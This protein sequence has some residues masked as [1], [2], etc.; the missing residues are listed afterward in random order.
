MANNRITYATAQL[1]IKDN[2]LNTSTTHIMGSVSGQTLSSGTTAAA[3]SILLD[4]DVSSNWPATGTIIIEGSGS[5]VREYAT[6]T[7]ITTATLTGVTR[8]A[9]GTTG[10]IHAS[11]ANRNNIRTRR[12]LHVGTTWIL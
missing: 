7:G 10:A 1:A 2:A 3:A 4:V 8:G 5:N 6:Y 11:G 9:F 12:Y